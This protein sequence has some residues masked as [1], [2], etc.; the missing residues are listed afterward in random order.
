[1]TAYQAKTHDILFQ[2]LNV[3]TGAGTAGIQ[4]AA[5][6]VSTSRP[7]QYQLT[8][9]LVDTW[10]F[11]DLGGGYYILTLPATETATLGLFVYQ[12]TTASTSPVYGSLDID[13]QPLSALASPSTCLITGNVAQLGGDFTDAVEVIFR[14]LGQPAHLGSSFISSHAVRTF[15]DGVGNFSVAL[16]RG[17]VA[18]VDI[19]DCGLKFQFTVPQQQTADLSSLL[20]V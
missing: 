20:P 15:T 4:K 8:P 1:M 2:L 6:S 17:A 14:P 18:S 3:Q 10:S 16:V 5:L 11:V 19:E 9:R 13:P 12:L 7:G